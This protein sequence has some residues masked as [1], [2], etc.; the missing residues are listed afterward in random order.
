MRSAILLRSCTGVTCADNC[1]T[2]AT[3]CTTGQSVGCYQLASSADHCGAC[4][5][6][7]PSCTRNQR[8]NVAATLIGSDRNMQVGG[9]RVDN[10][11][12]SGAL[13]LNPALTS[14]ALTRNTTQA[15]RHMA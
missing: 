4:V 2:G 11:T 3:Q 9:G 7:V 10:V 14:T 1:P 15:P 12:Y 5:T 13:S 6:H 8:S